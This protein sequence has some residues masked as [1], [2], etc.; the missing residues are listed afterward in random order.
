M[1]YYVTRYAEKDVHLL[2]RGRNLDKSFKSFPP[3]YSQSPLQLCP[4]I[5]IFQAHAISYIFLQTHAN[6]LCISTVQLLYTVKEK[7]GK[8]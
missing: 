3:C 7:G 5:Y 8:T 4:E 2:Y 6:L 1:N